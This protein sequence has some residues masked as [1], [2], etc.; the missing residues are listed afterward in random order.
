MLSSSNRQ[1]T[2]PT[3]GQELYS[4]TVSPAKLVTNLPF[5]HTNHL[6]W[7]PLDMTMTLGYAAT[8]PVQDLRQQNTTFAKQS[9][10]LHCGRPR[11]SRA[12]HASQESTLYNRVCSRRSCA[13]V[14]LLLR[15]ASEVNATTC[16][17]V[18]EIH[19]YYH[20]DYSTG[21]MH[22]A[23]H[24]SELHAESSLGNWA[25]L[26]GEPFACHSPSQCHDKLPTIFEEPQYVDASTKPSAKAVRGA[27][28]GRGC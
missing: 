23:T 7:L 8:G 10:C 21:N 6:S 4:Y 16:A 19:H 24:V 2:S 25:E 5:R 26:P 3:A 15:R 14:K 13:E 22:A 1:L 11:S 12:R 20:T 18:V 28:S 17:I 9:S 27:L